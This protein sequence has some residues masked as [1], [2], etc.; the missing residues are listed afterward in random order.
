MCPTSF[1]TFPDRHFGQSLHVRYGPA[2]GR[3]SEARGQPG[4]PWATR[5]GPSR[6]SVGIRALGATGLP[7]FDPDHHS[8]P[9]SSPAF[10]CSDWSGK[11]GDA[12][13]KP[14]AR[15]RAPREPGFPT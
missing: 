4:G 15:W 10:G 6:P 14:L 5:L 1:R 9:V 12:A 2:T 13:R 8:V 7:S 11:G 3:A